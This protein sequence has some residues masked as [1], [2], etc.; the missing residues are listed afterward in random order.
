[1]RLVAGPNCCSGRVEIY[2]NDTWWPVRDDGWD[3]REAQ[4]VCRQL[5]CGRAL[6]AP[7]HSRFGPGDRNLRLSGVGCAGTESELSRCSHALNGYGSWF[8]MQD[9]GV[10]CEGKYGWADR[11]KLCFVGFPKHWE[12]VDQF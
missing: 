12:H 11:S 8:Q 6:S 4:V 7:G 5:G 2:Y 9:A 1:M 3:L 10:I